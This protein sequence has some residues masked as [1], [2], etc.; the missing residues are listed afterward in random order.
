MQ[1]NN[2]LQN[3]GWRLE[4]A[5]LKA[6]LRARVRALTE[7]TSPIAQLDGRFA[8]LHKRPD[9][10]GGWR[11]SQFDARGFSGHSHHATRAD[12]I[13]ELARGGYEPAPSD[14]LDRLSTTPEWADG[15]LRAH[16]MDAFNRCRDWSRKTRAENLVFERGYSDETVTEARSLLLGE[17]A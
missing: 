7:A 4:I 2:A 16:Y 9:D 15:M 1:L 13:A 12:A 8:L 10:S 6:R 3:K 11:L 14:T 5:R 17:V